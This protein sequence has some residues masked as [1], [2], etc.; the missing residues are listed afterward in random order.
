MLFTLFTNQGNREYNEDSYGMER[1][2]ESTC[3]VL[4]DGL[5]GHGGGDVASKAAVT[6]V[7]KL[8]KSEGYSD[9]FFERAFTLAQEEIIKEQESASNFNG[10]KTTLVVLVI[11]DGNAYYA[12][13]GDSRLYFLKNGRIKTR[14]YD[15]S[16]PQMLALS[17]EIKESE[18]RHHPDRSKLLRVLGV[19][20]E[21]PKC[22][23]AK[24]IK[25]KGNLSFLICSDG[26]WELVGDKD[27]EST[28]R[29]ADD[30]DE[31]IDN[32]SA[33]VTKN[34]EGNDMDNYSAIAVWIDDGDTSI[35]ALE[36]AQKKDFFKVEF[37]EPGRGDLHKR[38]EKK[39]RREKCDEVESE[40][41]TEML[42]EGKTE[43]L[44]NDTTEVL[45]SAEDRTEIL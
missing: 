2:G 34:G 13:V 24:P 5:G 1:H 9:T 28:N 21:L 32:L 3:F 18:I 31:W 4:A 25:L 29:A 35:N 37:E 12:H 36:E 40:D 15:H 20:D 45:D 16:V 23:V 38:R 26:F 30:T 27:I 43:T 14:T 39:V 41:K 8:F 22:D 11:S 7:C 6:T 10:M 17:K 33:L 44:S 42:S 19:K